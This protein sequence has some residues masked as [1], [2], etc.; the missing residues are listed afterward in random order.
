MS[1]EWIC[2]AGYM[3]L[4]SAEFIDAYRN[5]VLNV[6]PSLLPAFA[7]THAQKQAWER[8]V[9]VTGVTVHLVDEK[10][11]HGPILLQEALSI[12]EGETL[13]EMEARL[14]T[15]EHEIYPKAL[16]FVLSGDWRL[17]GRRIVRQH[18]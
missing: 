2:L 7:G 13:E 4:L 12:K 15:I 14:L 16:A 11:D 3:R 1:A 6:H 9:Q 17:E 10:L 18:R 5:R 8:G